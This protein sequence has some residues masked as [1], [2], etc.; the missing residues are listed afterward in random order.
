MVI[1]A[2][3]QPSARSLGARSKRLSCVSQRDRVLISPPPP[4]VLCGLRPPR[5]KILSGTRLDK[6]KQS[7]ETLDRLLGCG[8]H[9]QP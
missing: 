6:N 1:T 8:S 4:R 5:C 7:L 9:R 3:P 2:K